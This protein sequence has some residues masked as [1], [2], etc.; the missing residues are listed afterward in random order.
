V[1]KAGNAAAPIGAAELPE[2]AC[3]QLVVEEE[4]VDLMRVLV[5]DDAHRERAGIQQVGVEPDAPRCGE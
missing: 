2:Q 3:A 1:R 4:E 5:L